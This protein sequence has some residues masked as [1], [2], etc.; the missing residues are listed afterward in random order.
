M[1]SSSNSIY[2]QVFVWVILAGSTLAQGI[3]G[4]IGDPAQVDQIVV[5]SEDIKSILPT[6]DS[7]GQDINSRLS[8]ANP[9]LAEIT[10]QSERQI[11][12]DPAAPS[13]SSATPSPH[14]PLFVSDNNVESGLDE[15]LSEE[16][17]IAVSDANAKIS[18][19]C[20]EQPG[21]AQLIWNADCTPEGIDLSDEFPREAD[22]EI[23]TREDGIYLRL[24]PATTE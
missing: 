22:G 14:P 10:T 7:D 18:M 4:E 11:E 20:D 21:N 1:W 16:A 19:D 15:A 12:A 3:E 13:A 2:K 23:L 24:D 6:V 9:E 8:D 5:P 17:D